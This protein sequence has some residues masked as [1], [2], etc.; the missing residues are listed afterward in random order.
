MCLLILRW[1]G[2]LLVATIVGGFVTELFL[3]RIRKDLDLKKPNQGTQKRVRPWLTGG[4]ERLVFAVFVAFEASGIIPGMMAWLA[5]KLVTNWNRQSG[6]NS[7]DDAKEV[8]A[9]LA[10]TAMLA[11]LLSMLFAFLAGIIWRGC[12]PLPQGG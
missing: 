1:V 8:K 3:R 12:K 9:A 6:G 4:I 10:F 11:G 2:G 5:L 7:S